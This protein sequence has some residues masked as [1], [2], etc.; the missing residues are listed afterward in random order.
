M[1]IAFI[2][3]EHRVNKLQQDKQVK[4]STVG[5]HGLELLLLIF[6]VG[7][8]IAVGVPQGYNFAIR[9]DLGVFSS[10]L[11]AIAGGVSV[12]LGIILSCYIIAA[13]IYLIRHK[14]DQ[15]ELNDYSTLVLIVFLAILMIISFIT[16]LKKFVLW[17][18]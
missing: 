7:L 2:G 5:C 18:M 14:K 9:H 6:I 16:L 11:I 8:G 15:W 12:V 4:P 1:F 3:L 17:I 10:V 13:P